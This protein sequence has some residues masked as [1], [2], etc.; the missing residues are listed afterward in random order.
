MISFKF[1]T[2]LALTILVQAFA[3]QSGAVIV[4][5]KYGGVYE[6]R[7]KKGSGWLAYYLHE[8]RPFSQLKGVVVTQRGDHFEAEVE[9]GGSRVDL[10]PMTCPNCYST[11]SLEELGP[12]KSC[13]ALADLLL[14]KAS[15][16]PR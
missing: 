1:P 5:G 7:N 4:K 3:A 6:L 12:A 14:Q 13:P 9:G 8:G 11:Y 10:T 15:T 16:P 2:K